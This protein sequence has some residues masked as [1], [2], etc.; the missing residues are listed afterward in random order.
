MYYRV[1]IV[2]KPKISCN[3][4]WTLKKDIVQGWKGAL[5]LEK[6]WGKLTLRSL[7]AGSYKETRDNVK[8][9]NRPD[10]AVSKPAMQTVIDDR[11][12]K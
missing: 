12:V 10:T 9:E 4:V 1:I 6:L 2:S 7:L 5:N 11:V 8:H 3:I